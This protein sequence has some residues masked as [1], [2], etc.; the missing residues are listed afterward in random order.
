MQF[1][2]NFY[3]CLREQRIRELKLNLNPCID[4]RVIVSLTPTR[5]NFL[6]LIN[7]F[8]IQN[9]TLQNVLQNVP[10]CPTSGHLLLMTRGDPI[11]VP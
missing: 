9:I 5:I 10:T 7:V 3:E 1:A 11:L 4:C 2:L 6:K 8:K